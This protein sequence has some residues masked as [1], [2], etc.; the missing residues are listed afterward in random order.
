MKTHEFWSRR[1]VL[2]GSFA[3]GGAAFALRSFPSRRPAT[4]QGDITI[5]FATSTTQD[6][7]EFAAMIDLFDDF[8][9]ANPGIMV[10]P[11]PIPYDNFMETLTTRVV[12]G[13][14]PD[15]ALLLDRFTTALVGQEA[16]L[17][18]DEYLPEGYAESF[19]PAPWNFAVVAGRPYAIPL[20]TN[21]QA[22]IYNIDQFKAAGVE[23]P[24]AP[25]DAWL[26]PEV[27]AVAAQ[28]KAA[29]GTEYGLIHWP[30]S[31]PS[32]LSP[33]LVAA[34]GSVLTEDLSASALD[35]P[36]AIEL[37]EQVRQTFVD[38]LAPE[39]NW[40]SPAEM[41][42]L[43]S[44]GQ[45][46]M[47]LASGNFQIPEATETVGDQFRWSFTYMPTTL[48]TPIELAAFNQT[49][50]PAE[51]AAL[52]MFLAEPENMARICRAANL[53]PTRTDLPA[54]SIDYP[55]GADQMAILQRQATVASE[56]IQREMKHP[57][58][59]EIDLM[60]RDKLEQL[61]LGSLTAA[62]VIEEGSIEIEQ[63]LERYAPSG[64]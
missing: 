35:S 61:A 5:R 45:S 20:Y 59:S 41:F 6:S 21:V 40:T 23:V 1:T 16:L 7:A 14:A 39:D 44:T 37:L 50:N 8:E 43:W 19:L 53:V 4:A 34:G 24:G 29:T 62:Q 10:E 9:A 60:L 15:A 54:E 12:G 51:T 56:R 30:N 38:G 64:S 36:A 11:Q 17:P 31:T 33:Y 46:S 25:E 13:Q 2:K 42:N 57:A 3:A 32:R 47:L 48:G 28:T 52:L 58:W 55:V 49:E 22:I 27:A 63:F 18:L 26:F